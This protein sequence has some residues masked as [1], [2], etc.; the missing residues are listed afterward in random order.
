MAQSTP[1]YVGPNV[2]K[3]SIAAAHAQGQSADSPVYLGARSARA[4]PTS[5]WR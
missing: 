3:N 2:H 5:T 1:L 4:T